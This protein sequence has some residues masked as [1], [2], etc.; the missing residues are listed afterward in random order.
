MTESERLDYLIKALESGNA[1]EFGRK[2]GI[3]KANAAKMRKGVIGYKKHIN[4][5]LAV[6]PSV[7]RTWLESGEGYPGDL[8]VDIVKAHFQTKLDRNESLI[9]VLI[10]RIEVLESEIEQYKASAK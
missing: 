8:T 10:K 5:I 3:S 4:S 1:T 2:I 6:Y 9:D 7:N